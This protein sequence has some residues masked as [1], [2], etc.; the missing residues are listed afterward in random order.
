MISRAMR[1]GTLNWI[2]AALLTGFSTVAQPSQKQITFDYVIGLPRER[3]AKPFQ[4]PKS[5]LPEEIRGDK[6][7]YDTY[8]QIKFRHDRALWSKDELPFRLEFFHPGYLY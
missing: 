3:S 7:N 2:W 5:E 8:R 1:W 6:L 4:Q